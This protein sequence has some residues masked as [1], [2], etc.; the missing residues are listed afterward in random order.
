MLNIYIFV[1]GGV[2]LNISSEDI[3]SYVDFLIQNQKLYIS[4]H[5]KIAS[6]GVFSRLNIHTHPYCLYVKKACHLEHIC[7]H[8][9]NKVL[10]HCKNGEFFGVCHAGVGEFIYPLK[11]EEECF[12]FISISGY[13]ENSDKCIKRKEKLSGSSK[14]L[15][16]NLPSKKSIDTLVRPLVHMCELYYENHKAE[17][18]GDSLIFNIIEYV[19][20][21]HTQNITRESLSKKFNYSISSISHKFTTQVGMNLTQYIEKLRIEDA[22]SLLVQTDLQITEMALLLGFCNCGHFSSVFKKNIGSSP[23]QYRKKHKKRT[24]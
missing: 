6:F 24:I 9:Q 19:N 7:I 8:Q 3:L 18:M 22:K 2:L 13:S 4:F 5:G 1:Q 11:N 20:K 23:N 16:Y 15:F 14:Y 12:G 21:N 10:N 17:L